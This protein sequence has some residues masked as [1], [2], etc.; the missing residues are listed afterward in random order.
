MY[1]MCMRVHCIHFM[2]V[3]VYHMQCV[4]VC[5]CKYMCECVYVC[6][7]IYALEYACTAKDH[8]Y[9]LAVLQQTAK[10]SECILYIDQ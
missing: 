10:S 8:A 3:Y 9:K 6:I 7:Y 1:V 5:V 4:S 2:Y